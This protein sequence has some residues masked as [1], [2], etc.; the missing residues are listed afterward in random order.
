M[1]R[2]DFDVVRHTKVAHFGMHLGLAGLAVAWQV[3]ADVLP[4]CSRTI[5]YVLA[6]AAAVLYVAWLGLYAF[7]A[8]E[9]PRKVR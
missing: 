7:R 9:Y 3:A 5:S 4:A 1:T 6:L 2:E 8:F